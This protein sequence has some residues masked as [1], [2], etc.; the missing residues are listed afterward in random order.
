[1]EETINKKERKKE[2]EKKLEKEIID[3]VIARLHTFPPNA[4]LSIGGEESL[5]IEKMIEHVKANDEKGKLIVETQLDYIRSLKDLP[6]TPEEYE[7]SN[8]QT[9]L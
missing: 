7:S 9:S 6:I 5:T 4:S 1:M 2:E 8:H 3:L